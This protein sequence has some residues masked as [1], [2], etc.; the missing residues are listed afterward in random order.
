MCLRM[1]CAS[2]W[3]PPGSHWVDLYG[4]SFTSS[5]NRRARTPVLHSLSSPHCGCHTIASFCFWCL[6]LCV[7]G[8]CLYLL[9]THLCKLQ[10]QCSMT[11]W[12]SYWS[13][14]RQNDLKLA[15]ALVTRT[16]FVDEYYLQNVAGVFKIWW[17]NSRKNNE[18][19]Q[20]MF[21]SSQFP[22]LKDC[23]RFIF[24]AHVASIL[25]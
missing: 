25:P 18:L 7:V 1:R 12:R 10:I 20:K 2:K 6:F 5:E 3:V 4:S 16:N 19:T 17:S 23:V 9:G 8:V 15:I 14:N 11:S 22:T 21:T 24:K 13:K